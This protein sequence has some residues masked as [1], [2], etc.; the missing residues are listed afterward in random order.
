ML[1][2]LT[3]SGK[4]VHFI[5]YCDAAKSKTSVEECKLLYS[6][7]KDR[8]LI[9]HEPD[10]PPATLLH[11]TRTLVMIVHFAFKTTDLLTQYLNKI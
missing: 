3:K 10:C 5:F 2:F 4:L 8:S 11:K 7:L 6:S 1:Y 9:I